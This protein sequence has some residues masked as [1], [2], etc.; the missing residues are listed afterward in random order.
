MTRDAAVAIGPELENTLVAVAVE[1][2]ADRT[3]S[4]GCRIEG[5]I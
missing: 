3:T 5:S 4:R 1:P 2:R